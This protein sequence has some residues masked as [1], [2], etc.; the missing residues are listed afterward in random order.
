M[1]ANHR[2]MRDHLKELSAV[3]L[4]GVIGGCEQ[5]LAGDPDGGR[6]HERQRHGRNHLQHYVRSASLNLSAGFNLGG[7]YQNAGR[8]RDPNGNFA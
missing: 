3:E 1:D 7:A 2:R 5:H 8:Q 6:P 4:D